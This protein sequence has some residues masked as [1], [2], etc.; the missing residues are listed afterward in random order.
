MTELD[1]DVEEWLAVDDVEDGDLD[2]E[3]VYI[4]VLYFYFF[5]VI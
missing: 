2:E 4:F 3:L 1:E 5:I